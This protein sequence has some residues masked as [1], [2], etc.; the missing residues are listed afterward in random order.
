[1]LSFEWVELE[2]SCVVFLLWVL[3]FLVFLVER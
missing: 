2:I 3:P 1:M